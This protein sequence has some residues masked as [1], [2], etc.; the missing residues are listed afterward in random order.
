MRICI[1]SIKYV[2]ILLLFWNHVIAV[3][4]LPIESFNEI[5]S[6]A[7]LKIILAPKLFFVI[8]LYES[9]YL[10]IKDFIKLKSCFKIVTNVLFE[11]KT[12]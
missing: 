9:W 2:T 10:K 12:K 4:I 5:E 11:L 1:Q 8:K 3:A 6:K 7:L